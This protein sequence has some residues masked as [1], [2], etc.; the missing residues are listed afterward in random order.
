[1]RHRGT[2]GKRKN[3]SVNGLE[4]KGGQTSEGEMIAKEIV[5]ALEKPLSD[6]NMGD[7]TK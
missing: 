5:D 6:S 2:D 7:F 1:M 3:K 4:V